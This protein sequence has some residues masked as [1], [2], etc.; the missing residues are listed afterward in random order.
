[1]KTLSILAT[2]IYQ[3]LSKQYPNLSELREVTK[4]YLLNE[5]TQWTIKGF[6]QNNSY[7]IK[8]KEFSGDDN[9]APFEVRLI[10][11]GDGSGYHELKFGNLNTEDDE[12]RYAWDNK[13]PYRLQKALFLRNVLESVVVKLL[14]ADK[15]KGVLFQPYNGDGLG[16]QRYSYFY[17][18]YSKLK[19]DGYK[20]NKVGHNTYVI[21]K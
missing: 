10:D 12:D 3:D 9:S 21:T 4:H 6:E 14:D 5:V 7:F 13:D 20:L 16:D 19:K 2:E 1:M 11:I 8:P 18:M 17:N 15:I